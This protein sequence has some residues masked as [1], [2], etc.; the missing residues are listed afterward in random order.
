M[1]CKNKLQS[2]KLMLI[3]I[4]K[5]NFKL[6]KKKKIVLKLLKV[7]IKS[8]F[9]TII[10]YYFFFLFL[11]LFIITFGL[12]DPSIKSIKKSIEEK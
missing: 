6:R 2:L 12:N 1:I 9:Y 8:A 3:A 10:V 11:H 4:L 7:L 5:T